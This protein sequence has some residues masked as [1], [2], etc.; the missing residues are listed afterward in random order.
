[1]TR[2]TGVSA[3][4]YREAGWPSCCLVV[5]GI[6]ISGKSRHKAANLGRM[7]VRNVVGLCRTLPW[8]ADE[9][10]GDLWG[11]VLPGGI[12]Y[13]CRPA[14]RRGVRLLFLGGWL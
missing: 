1:M 5:G 2:G 3:A 11:V 10:R 8:D 4:G 12:H 13:C 9:I 14:R 7:G 6:A